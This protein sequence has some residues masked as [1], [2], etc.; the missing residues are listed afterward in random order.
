MLVVADRP[1]ITTDIQDRLNEI[2]N[3]KTAARKILFLLTA[4]ARILN[5]QD[6]S[7]IMD[8]TKA[9][10]ET[11]GNVATVGQLFKATLDRFNDKGEVIDVTT[12]AQLARDIADEKV[13]NEIPL[14]DR[15]KLINAIAYDISYYLE[16]DGRSGDFETVRPGLL[17]KTTA[18]F[19]D[20]QDANNK[21]IDYDTMQIFFS[22][23]SG[24]SDISVIATL[25]N[26]INK[27]RGITDVWRDNEGNEIRRDSAFH[28]ANYERGKVVLKALLN[29]MVD[30]ITND[31]KDP[32]R[33]NS[34]EAIK[35]YDR[36]THAISVIDNDEM[37]NSIMYEI[38]P[39]LLFVNGNY[40]YISGVGK[41]LITALFENKS[42]DKDMLIEWVGTA[43][44]PMTNFEGTNEALLN[45]LTLLSNK[46][47]ISGKPFDERLSAMFG[48]RP[49][50][51]ANMPEEKQ[52]MLMQHMM[53][54]DTALF[55]EPSGDAAG[56]ASKIKGML[57]SAYERQGDYLSAN[58]EFL[59]SD[60]S[61][62]KAL[63][64]ASTPEVKRALISKVIGTIDARLAGSKDWTD[65][66]NLN[67]NKF[68]FISENKTDMPNAFIVDEKG[69]A[70]KTNR[71]LYLQINALKTL[72]ENAPDILLKT[73]YVKAI[74]KALDT[75]KAKKISFISKAWN[76]IKE[77]AG[78]IMDGLLELESKAEKNKAQQ[79]APKAEIAVK[80]QLALP[81]ASTRFLLPSSENALGGF[82][83]LISSKIKGSARRDRLIKIAQ[84][85][86]TASDNTGNG[87]TVG[88]VVKSLYG[89]ETPAVTKS[90]IYRDIEWL[91]KEAGILSKQ[92]AEKIGDSNKYR[93]LVEKAKLEGLIGDITS[94]IQ[95][96]G[97]QAGPVT[98]TAAPMGTLATGSMPE[99]AT[100][101]THVVS[102]VDI[103]A[104]VSPDN[105]KMINEAINQFCVKA[106][107]V[108]KLNKAQEKA[109]NGQIRADQTVK[110]IMEATG[111][112]YVITCGEQGVKE[113]DSIIDILKARG[114]TILENLKLSYETGYIMMNNGAVVLSNKAVIAIRQDGTI[115]WMNSTKSFESINVNEIAFT[116]HT[117]PLGHMISDGD[118]MADGLAIKEVYNIT[119]R[120]IPE[121]VTARNESG[122]MV[123][124][125]ISHNA[126]TGDVNISD[127]DTAGAINT[128]SLGINASN[129]ESVTSSTGGSRLSTLTLE[130]VPVKIDVAVSSSNGNINIAQSQEAINKDKLNKGLTGFISSASKELALAVAKMP[131]DK[132]AQFQKG[133][134]SLI[135]EASLAAKGG[136]GLSET[137]IAERMARLLQDAGIFGGTLRP[138][139]VAGERGYD[140]ETIN[141]IIKAIGSVKDTGIKRE[142]PEPVKY[143]FVVGSDKEKDELNNKLQGAAKAEVVV[144]KAG[145]DIIQTVQETLNISSVSMMSIATKEGD[146]ESVESIRMHYEKTQTK[147]ADSRINSLIT[148]EIEASEQAKIPAAALVTILIKLASQGQTTVMTVGCTPKTVSDL[149]Q[150]LKN[151]FR[152]FRLA[153]LQIEKV[154][155]EFLSAIQATAKSV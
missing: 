131:P 99:F 1:S 90:T 86:A 107:E 85:F 33:R 59:R 122:E 43:L 74:D 135:D 58:K 113:G 96:A 142:G 47:E 144:V 98:I 127:M 32:I 8:K 20:L 9:S 136:A 118:F 17:T 35:Q 65:M 82:R 79:E 18:A 26:Y 25:N 137:T 50:D 10:I 123:T 110:V 75:L 152:F 148:G 21:A 100:L 16:P 120:N 61:Y 69:A 60:I 46:L 67:L 62:R 102:A 129:I 109:E 31:F 154:M 81:A 52:Q 70:E 104:K 15:E 88:D 68:Y 105:A 149:Q 147:G 115:N 132:F 48:V 143:I 126:K 29:T 49:E 36:L 155:Q 87:F 23:V 151:G 2:M 124:K 24:M 121:L 44:S 94:H 76:K 30:S 53:K 112:E 34:A 38:V 6:I 40:T 108:N 51:L 103:M 56:Q 128:R 150:A 116:G 22:L 37:I 3:K 19:I 134:K 78:I 28:A 4:D 130:A 89:N 72:K 5:R 12:F 77:S 83:D 64:L 106:D 14:T 114:A 13:K 97:P 146:R 80:Q 117:H 39:K 91:Q 141:E 55:E 42:I 57:I 71:E 139:I 138:I 45:E 92:S 27:E 101:G 145:Q 119:G 125:V 41:G 133:L 54:Q 140:K 73:L 95:K 153:K 7:D 84:F 93:S 63:S 11:L 111:T 66:V